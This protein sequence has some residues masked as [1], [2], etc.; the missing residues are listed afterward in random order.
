[1]G[2]EGL[3]CNPRR[4]LADNADIIF[5]GEGGTARMNSNSYMLLDERG[6]QFEQKRSH[7]E[8]KEHLE[9]LVAAIRGE[10]ALN[11][12]IAEGHRSALL[13]NLG[14]IAYRTGATL[15]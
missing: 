8:Q 1:M 6:K 3:S 11:A 15:K 5:Y 2:F 7:G 4:P 12:E 10:A 14:N 9:N 13:C